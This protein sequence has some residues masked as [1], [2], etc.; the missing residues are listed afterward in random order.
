MCSVL[1]SISLHRIV[2]SGL[3]KVTKQMLART[4]ARTPIHNQPNKRTNERMKQQTNA[5][6]TEPNNREWKY[7]NLIRNTSAATEYTVYSRMNHGSNN[8]DDNDV[9]ETKKKLF[10][11]EYDTIVAMRVCVIVLPT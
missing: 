3:F 2:F 6:R 8:D 10:F 7:K 9:V 11:C 1:C 5:N 4:L